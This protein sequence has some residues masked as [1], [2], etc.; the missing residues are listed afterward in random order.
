MC[1]SVYVCESVCVYE[2]MCVSVCKLLRKLLYCIH[3]FLRFANLCA[4]RSLS[5][6]SFRLSICH[7]IVRIRIFYD[8]LYSLSPLLLSSFPCVYLSVFPNK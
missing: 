2:C 8:C 3:F 7:N 6:F 5:H 1:D 4:V